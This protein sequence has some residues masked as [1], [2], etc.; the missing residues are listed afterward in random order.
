MPPPLTTLDLPIPKLRSGKVRE[1]FDLGETLL[2]VVT[3]RI[4]AFDCILPD[5]IP[6]QR[7]GP[8]PDFRLLVS[9]L[10]FCAEPHGRGAVRICPTDLEPFREQLARRSM[11]VRKTEPLPVEC[12]VRGYLAGSGWKD[13]QETRHAF[14]DTNCRRVWSSRRNCRSQ[15]SPPRP[16]ASKAMTRTST[17]RNAAASLGEEIAAPGRAI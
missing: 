9:A 3:D 16:R 13:Y 12:V 15:S 14:A 10:H 5:P 17:G 4:S 2:F 8:E 1:V 11:I 6:G 7:R